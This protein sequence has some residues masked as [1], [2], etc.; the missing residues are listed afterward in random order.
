MHRKTCSLG[1]K[2][3]VY[4]DTSPHVTSP[5]STRQHVRTPVS[6]HSP[7][8]AAEVITRQTLSQATPYAHCRNTLTPLP[9]QCRLQCRM[10]YTAGFGRLELER[11]ITCNGHRHLLRTPKL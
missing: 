3:R 6:M 4:A 7:R 2:A 9:G 10:K 11:V 1:E 5:G 8:A